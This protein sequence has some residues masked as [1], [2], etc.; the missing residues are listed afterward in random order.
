MWRD[1][2]ETF[3]FADGTVLR[4]KE[5]GIP[6]RWQ[7]VWQYVRGTYSYLDSVRMFN[8][9]FRQY[10]NDCPH[11]DFQG[12]IY[13]MDRV[14]DHVEM[15]DRYESHTVRPSLDLYWQENMR[16]DQTLIFNLVGTYNYTDNTRIYQELSNVVSGKVGDRL[17]TDVCNIV[18]G[19][20]YSWIVEGI[21]EKGLGN[22]RFSAGL[23]HMQSYSANTYRGGMGTELSNTDMNQN[24]TYLY[25]EWRGHF[26]E[27][28]YMLG[29]G[30]TRSSFSQENA[31]GEYSRYTFNPRLTLSLPVTGKSTFRLK[32]Y[33]QNKT[34][35]LSELSDVEQKIDSIR[36]QRGN[37]ELKP[38]LASYSELNCEWRGGIFYTN[39]SGVY[40]YM[41]TPV[42]DEKFWEGNRVIQ[43][44]S[45]QR[46]WR[47]LSGS[48]HVRMGPWRDIFTLSV[49][50]GINHYVSDG[51]TYRHVYTNPYISVTFNG[52]HKN[53]LSGISWNTHY[54]HFYGETLS[55]GESMHLI[56]LGYKYRGMKFEC[57]VFC[58]F[59]NNFYRDTESWSAQAS[60]RKTLY[61]NDISRLIS[62]RYSHTFS[63]GRS[64]SSSSAPRLTNRDDDSGIMKTSK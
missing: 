57:A 44:W 19:N 53:F 25:G 18:T 24:E 40:E 23:R 48:L 20:K 21:Y 62:L 2:E 14:E 56:F 17:L 61:S 52:N 10:L 6:D 43:S 27:L 16:N 13:N 58:P 63:F 4:R 60:S 50:G 9:T 12:E 47:R 29:G 45:N 15:I 1:N 51:H 3:R 41:F 49:T 26:G 5:A 42:M 64:S 34:P 54:D 36:F 28:N 33:I 8:V 7:E 39:L 32:T 35:S 31:G 38:Y 59:V 37:P 46:S 55:G 22:N 30:V 11:F